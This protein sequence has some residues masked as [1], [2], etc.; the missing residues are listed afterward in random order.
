MLNA[1]AAMTAFCERI[2]RGFWRRVLSVHEFSFWAWVR[3][4]AYPDAW[5]SSSRYDRWLTHRYDQMV[6][7]QTLPGGELVAENANPLDRYAR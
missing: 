5:T 7:S 1:W 2:W 4:Q 3:R 6:Y